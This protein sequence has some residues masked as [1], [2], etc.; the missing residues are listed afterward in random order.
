MLKPTKRL[1]KKQMKE[2]KLVTTYFKVIDYINQNS[3]IVSGVI[4]GIAAIILLT[5]LFIRSK[6][7]AEINASVEL[8]K[9]RVELLN[10]NGET[11]AD[12]LQSLIQNYGGTRTAG[13]GVFYLANI[14]YEQEKYDESLQYYQK[15]LDDYDDDIIISSSSYSGMAACFEQKGEYLKAANFYKDGAEKY[16]EHFEA[17]RQ[18]MS[19]ARC[20][21]LANNK[22]EARKLYQLIIDKYPESKYKKNAEL[23]LNELQG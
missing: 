15:Y 18:L 3:K 14:Y 22:I 2:D 9:A 7:S 17:S 10:N 4:I 8:T 11:A 6:R 21:R 19:A 12:I 20:F 13:R 5:M 23:Y 16:S 1:T